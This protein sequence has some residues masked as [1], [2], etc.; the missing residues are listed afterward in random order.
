MQEESNISNDEGNGR[1]FKQIFWKYQSTLN[2]Y[3][4]G[5]NKAFDEI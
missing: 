1:Y 3:I 4:F 5:I 2:C